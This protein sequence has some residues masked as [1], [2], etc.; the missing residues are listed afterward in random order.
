MKSNDSFKSLFGKEKGN[1][2]KTEDKVPLIKR[3]EKPVHPMV[4]LIIVGVIGV[5]G[6]VAAVCMHFSGNAKGAHA[7]AFL[8]G[9]VLAI[10]AA[11]I[12]ASILNKLADKARTWREEIKNNKAISKVPV[13]LAIAE[14][15]RNTF[16]ALLTIPIFSGLKVAT[17]LAKTSEKFDNSRPNP[18]SLGEFLFIAMAI[19]FGF[20]AFA[21]VF[22]LLPF[23]FLYSLKSLAEVFSGQTPNYDAGIYKLSRQMKTSFNPN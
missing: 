18:E 16:V 9:C 14:W 4:P 6:E 23:L 7:F 15:A 22:A 19:V 8:G 20:G 13:G 17:P 1:R 11:I 21:I 3:L 12:I 5:V 2:M 10:V